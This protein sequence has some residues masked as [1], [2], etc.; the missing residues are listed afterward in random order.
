[1]LGYDEAKIDEIVSNAFLT[2]SPTFILTG[3]VDYN[4]EEDYL[5]NLKLV[6]N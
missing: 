5:A 6:T 2:S 1:M 3:W 4:D